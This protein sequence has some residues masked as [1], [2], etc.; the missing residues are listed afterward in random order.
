[1]SPLSIVVSILV[2][3]VIVTIIAYIK[4]TTENARLEKA[5]LLSEYN[6]RVRRV[7]YLLNDIPIQMLNNGLAV[8]LLEEK[9]QAL[10]SIKTLCGKKVE[11]EVLN[12]LEAIKQLN[13]FTLSIM[14]IQFQ[15][16]YSKLT[17]IIT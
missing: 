14:G 9:Q 16:Y 8:F 4:H 2:L 15:I 1:M 5:R 12:H 17:R 13:S 6:S 3:I 11:A 7:D 10:E